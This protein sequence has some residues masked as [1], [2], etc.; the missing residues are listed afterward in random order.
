MIFIIF[1]YF[2]ILIGLFGLV[3]LQGVKKL[4]I[5]E[6]FICMFYENGIVLDFG[7]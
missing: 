7:Y 1:N 5:E 3:I 2:D 4:F 6:D